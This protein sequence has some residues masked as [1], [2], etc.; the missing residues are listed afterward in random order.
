MHP[1]QASE[2]GPLWEGPPFLPSR[3]SRNL[4][5]AVTSHPPQEGECQV[6]Q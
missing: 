4:L 2:T 1:T 3:P 5:E 6:G